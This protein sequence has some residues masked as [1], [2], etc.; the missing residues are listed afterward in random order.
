VTHVVAGRSI[1]YGPS[2]AKTKG[3]Q[4]GQSPAKAAKKL[5]KSGTK[6]AKAAAK[7]PKAAAKAAKPPKS[8]RVITKLPPAPPAPPPPPPPRDE[9]VSPRDIGRLTR[10]GERFG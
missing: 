5:I 8:T 4:K 9:L 3:T 1:C 10:Y 6:P 2:V 7:P